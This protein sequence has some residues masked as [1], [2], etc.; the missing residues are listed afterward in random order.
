[1][2]NFERYQTATIAFQMVNWGGEFLPYIWLSMKS[3]I[4][5]DYPIHRYS[6]LYTS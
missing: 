3:Y 6:W 2:F 5:L 4:K 1:M